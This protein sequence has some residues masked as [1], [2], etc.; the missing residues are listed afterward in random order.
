M[1]A[2]VSRSA[3]ELTDDEIALTVLELVRKL[4]TGHEAAIR[5]ESAPEPDRMRA[6]CPPEARYDFTGVA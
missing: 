6:Y 3:L 5:L 1:T 2:R 4:V